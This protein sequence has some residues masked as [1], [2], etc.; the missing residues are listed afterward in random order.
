M[1]LILTEIMNVKKSAWCI[2]TLLSILTSCK[3]NETTWDVDNTIPLFKTDLT[4]NSV[5][6][7]YLNQSSSDSGYNLEYE[8]L[9][10]S[11]KINDLQS[12]DTGID[13]S[14]NLKKLRLNDQIIQNKIT[15]GQINPLFNILDGQQADLPSQ[16]QKDL[17]PTDIDA[18][19]FFET[20]TLDTGY[21]D[22]TI[23]NE[24][25]VDLRLVVFELRNKSDNS[26]VAVDSFA[27]I[28]K[29]VGSSS[30]TIDLKGKT[31]TKSLVG[32]VKRL[33]TEA[34]GGLVL[35]ES[36][37]G[38]NVTLGV[39]NLRPSYAIAAFPTQNVIDQDE[40][41]TLYM[42]G[43]E[44]K[45]FKVASGRLR[46]K[47]ESTIQ[48]D[49]RM[50]LSLP[51]AIKDGKPF[52]QEMML[53]GPGGQGVAVTEQVYEMQGYLLDFRGK[54]PDVKDT[55][56]TFHQVL[57]VTLDSSG[58]KLAVGLKDSIRL[59]Y[60]IESLKPE[61]AIGYLGNTLSRTG[62][63][64]AAFDLFKG[65][66][67]DMKFKDVS[68]DFLLRNSI[69]TE[70]RMK[71]FKVDGKNT[72]S[73]Q[74]ISLDA[75]PLKS[76]LFVDKP[77]FNRGNY[78]ETKVVLNTSNSNI[79]EFLENLPQEL[80][81]DLETEISPNG[82]INNYTDFVFD[83]SKIDVIMK[84]KAPISLAIDGLVLR[85]TQGVDFTKIGNIERVKSGIMFIDMENTFPF[86]FSLE[87]EALN[88]NYKSVGSLDVHPTDGVASAV[89]DVNG[90][91]VNPS[92]STI[93]IH[94]PKSKISILKSAKFVAL[95]L[96]V[97]GGNSSNVKKIYN[98]SNVKMNAR[99]QFEYEAKTN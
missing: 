39:R 68:I 79:K 72:F 94:L 22:I 80:E 23:Q 18:S 69:G 77:S 24:L 38:I 90:F 44:V 75:D 8:N 71:L 13:A 2:F 55:V 73:N 97:N 56:N 47:V 30:K 14:F 66:S 84:M 26:L 40:G 78:T 87:V 93:S 74:S 28:S 10:Y 33:I 62:N 43:A 89:I 41:L 29:K 11:Y 76:D 64:K 61:Y 48:E 42:G 65:L 31:V 52:Y 98:T 81:Y 86:G 19:A 34:S 36:K 57:R 50:V 85:D 1:L 96:K 88:E 67:G 32:V 20:A 16:D 17:D 45:Y 6:A 46:I 70:G 27:N 7:K 21:L 82:N 37:K 83:D 59:E 91:L 99:L 53:P 12:S 58:R 25:P 35:I 92:K 51:G 95:K 4:F 63:S 54:D 9:L 5:D 15:L 3:K 49:M 60:R